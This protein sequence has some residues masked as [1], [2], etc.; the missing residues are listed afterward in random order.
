MK[1]LWIPHNPTGDNAWDGCRQD[2]LLRHLSHAHELHWVTWEQSKRLSDVRRWGALVSER[3]QIG[4]EH[5][6]VL[7]PNFYRLLTKV[8]PRTFHVAL[9]QNLFQRAVS[10]II[11]TIRPDVLVYGS[12]HHWTGYPP[13]D[14]GIP[15][16]FDHVDFSPRPIEATY[17]Q[18]AAAVVTVSDA[19]SAAVAEY[20]KPTTLIPNGV[21]LA[22]YASVDRQQAKAK[23]GLNDFTVVSLIGLTCSPTLY[24]IDA[25]AA[26]QQKLP[27][28]LL[29]IVGAGKTQEAIAQKA[30]D[31]SI[32]HLRLP[33]H[34]SNAE[35]HWYFA[36]TDVGLYPGEDIPYYRH[37]LPLK[38]VEYSAA[39]VQVVSSPVDMFR[40][41]WPNVRIAEPTAPAFA[42][43]I[44]SALN[45]PRPSADLTPYDWCTLACRFNTVLQSVV[46]KQDF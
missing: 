18:A 4:T 20:G 3:K 42:E 13:F 24:F 23:L 6:I 9:N 21:D 29:L 46:R 16:V 31:L 36:A 43:A 10:R 1:V 45:A 15:M 27:N 35:V 8:Y 33:G 44:L 32:K 17:T 25:L 39:G 22:R 2:H 14:S 41:G 19:L 12:S 26:L 28:V 7:A 37:A 11:D 5:R 38:I 30:R 34:V 40:H